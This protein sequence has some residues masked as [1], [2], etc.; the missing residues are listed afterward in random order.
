MIEKQKRLIRDGLCGIYKIL[1]KVNG[2]IYVGS[3]GNIK[4]RWQFHVYLLENNKHSNK[5]LQGAWNLYGEKNFKGFILE[6]CGIN[7]LKETEQFWLDE[8]SCYDNKIGY[9]FSKK[10]NFVSVSEESKVV[11]ANNNKGENNPNAVL[12][13]MEVSNIKKDY[14]TGQYTAKILS[15][16]YNKKDCTI[17]DIINGRRWKFVSPEIIKQDPYRFKRALISK[18]SV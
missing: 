18:K 17:S 11:I 4:E 14:N 16:K 7:K 5:H 1:N 12:S 13:S 6:I 3:S 8:S 2:K 10:A 15:K 9:N